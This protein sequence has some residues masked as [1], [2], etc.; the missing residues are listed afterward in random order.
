MYGLNI[1]PSLQTQPDDPEHP[2]DS[3]TA[4]SAAVLL[5]FALHLVVAVGTVHMITFGICQG[6]F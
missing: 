4:R 3:L 5:V 6:P 2:S 1:W